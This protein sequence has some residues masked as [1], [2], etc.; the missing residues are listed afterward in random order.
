MCGISGFFLKNKFD[1]GLYYKAHKEL[2]H[3]GPDD[4]GFLITEDNEFDGSVKLKTIDIRENASKLRQYGSSRICFGHHRLKVIDLTEGGH[5]PFWSEDHRYVVVY[6]GEIYNYI[7]LR[8]ELES[9]GYKFRSNSDTEVLISAFQHWQE[10]CFARFNGMWA[11]AILDTHSRRVYLSRDRFGIKPLYTCITDNGVIFASEL[12]FFR[13]LNLPLSLNVNVASNYINK[14]LLDYNEETFYNEIRAFPAAHYAVFSLDGKILTKAKYWE[15]QIG[16]TNEMSIEEASAKLREL[17]HS[18]LALRMRS[19]VSV[20]V[21]LSGGLDST[22]IVS[23]LC[24]YFDLPNSK[25]ASFSAVYEEEEFSEY[26]FIN[27]TV[28][29]YPQIDAHFVYPSPSDLRNDFESLVQTIETPFRSLSVFSQ[30]CLYRYVRRH[31]DVVVL[32]NGQGGDELFAGYSAYFPIYLDE[33]VKR[34]RFLL[35]VRELYY[36]RKYRNAEARKYLSSILRRIIGVAVSFGLRFSGGNRKGKYD[37]LLTY[38]PEPLSQ[39]SRTLNERLLYDLSIS[40][41]P[42]YLRYEDRNSM[43]FSLESRLPFLDYRMVEFMFQLDSHFKIS[44]GMSKSILRNAIQK[45]VVSSVLTRKD[46][47]G[48]VSPQ[49]IWQKTILKDWMQ[50]VILGDEGSSLFK[51]KEIEESYKVYLDFD[52]N[53]SPF[54]WWRIF[55][56]KYWYMR[57]LR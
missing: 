23:S 41:L 35:F 18:S 12:K 14:C 15:I 33:L 27:D 32:L 26:P 13:A 43:R 30:Y 11:L 24:R 1:L 5:Q 34:L 50:D 28:T 55:C 25:I 51:Q 4:H 48:F 19:D 37:S 21:L 38:H 17:F 45:D 42:E 56:F 8:E 57:F 16:A 46:K 31:S 6:N 49:E 29:Q 2:S 54:L 53:H 7:E 40:G 9:Y 39:D 3:R 47:M 44:Q 36:W 22:S 10:E 52:E 20:G